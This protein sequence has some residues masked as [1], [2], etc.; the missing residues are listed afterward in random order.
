MEKRAPAREDG[1][2][3]AC[4][5]RLISPCKIKNYGEN[6]ESGEIKSRPWGKEGALLEIL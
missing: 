3:A 6:R 4:R 2:R 5:M 1:K